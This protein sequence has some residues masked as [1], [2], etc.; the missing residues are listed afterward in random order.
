M[1]MMRTERDGGRM[2]AIPLMREPVTVAQQTA[3][4]D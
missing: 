3:S 2:L 1:T 4:M